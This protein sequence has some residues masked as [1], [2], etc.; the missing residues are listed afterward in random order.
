MSN[1]ENSMVWFLDFRAGEARQITR[2]EGAR[3]AM[4]MQA[5]TTVKD[6]ILYIDCEPTD[7]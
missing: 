7:D 5:R 3:R 1:P 6:G 2:E 4:E